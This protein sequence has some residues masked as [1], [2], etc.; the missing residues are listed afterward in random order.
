MGAFVLAWMLGEGIIVYRSVSKNHHPPMP[1]ALIAPSGIFM[2][3]A[4]LAES[5]AARPLAIT[6]AYAFDFAALMNL[7]PPVTGGGTA[8]APAPAPAAGAPGGLTSG[9]GPGA[10]GA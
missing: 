5:D 8:K 1:G 6:L 3:L 7:F 10:S 9:T 2:L 4:F